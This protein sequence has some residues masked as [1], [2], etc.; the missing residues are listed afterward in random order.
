[1]WDTLNRRIVREILDAQDLSGRLDSALRERRALLDNR[2]ATLAGEVQRALDEEPEESWA[3]PVRRVAEEI[4][5][6]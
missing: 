2:L 4:A 3:G 1:V 5:G 6:R